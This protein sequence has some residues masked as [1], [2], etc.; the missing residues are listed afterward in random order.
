MDLD[1]GLRNEATAALSPADALRATTPRPGSEPLSA[2][3][4]PEISTAVLRR[5]TA[6]ATRARVDLLTP[7]RHTA[8][9]ELEHLL[10]SME[11]WDPAALESPDPTMTVLA[12]AALQDLAGRLPCAAHSPLGARIETALALLHTIM[13]GT[14]QSA[15]A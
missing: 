8:A 3:I 1:P 9:D 6:L 2:V 5:C 7:S 14:R 15:M 4:G 12:A 13:E 11:P 10:A